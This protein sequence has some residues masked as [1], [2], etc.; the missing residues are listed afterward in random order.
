VR[1]RRRRRFGHHRKG[2]GPRAA[3]MRE[4]ERPSAGDESGAATDTKAPRSQR[5]RKKA[6]LASAAAAAHL[7]PYRRR[8]LSWRAPLSLATPECVHPQT[9]HTLSFYLHTWSI[10]P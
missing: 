4:R 5:S 1:V 6:T 2:A 8:T 9:T 10:Q 7:A 3:A